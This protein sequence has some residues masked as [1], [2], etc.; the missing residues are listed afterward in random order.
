MEQH[1]SFPWGVLFIVSLAAFILVIDTTTIEVSLSALAV[2]L[3]TDLTSIHSIIT[4]YTLVKASSML[5]G[6]KIQDIIGRKKTFMTGAAI[7]GVGTF[8]AAISQDAGMFLFGW[9]ILEGIGTVLMLPATVTFIT[10]A[11]KG[12]ER[13]FAFGVWGGIAAAASIF[14]LIFG[15]YL[16]TF[17]SW[18]WVFVLELVILLVIFAFHRVLTE[19]R[20]TTSWKRF[21]IGGALLSFFGLIALVFGIL[22]VKEPEKWVLVPFLVTGG[23]ILLFG[24]YLWERRQIGKETDILVDVTILPTRS[25]LAGNVVAIGQKF[26][27]AGFI[28]LFP[29]FYEIVAGASAYETGIALLPM[30]LAIVVF[31][32]LGARLASWFE[33]KYVLLGGI[34]LTGAGL[35]AIRDVFTLTT[36]VYDILSGSLLFGIGLGIVLS[37][38]T[39]LTL[40]SIRSERQTDASGIYNTTRQLGSSLG[41]AVIGIVLA[42]GFVAGLFPGR[43]LSLPS[44]QPLLSLG[45]SDAAVNQGM[46]WAFIAMILVVIGMFIAG[47]FIRKTG[48]IA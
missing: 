6:A 46:E 36:T 10:G 40:S 26:I 13:A 31:S 28:F 39:N 16:A 42:L 22:L 4:L 5:I 11:Y 15:G 30:S 37:Q 20:P 7:Y 32:I 34:A 17:Y 35:A 43:S 19:T 44:G 45:I 33:P 1:R 47:L 3:N 25:F 9:S 48:K 24:F 8:I 29:V 21:D 38:V 14:G 2:G 27:T 18:R 12:K 41:T 23:I